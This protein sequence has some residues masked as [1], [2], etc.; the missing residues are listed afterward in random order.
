[1]CVLPCAADDDTLF[2]A[3]PT[4][5]ML[6]NFWEDLRLASKTRVFRVS[7]RVRVRVWVR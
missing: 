3:A 2:G 1:M 4:L 5:N 7:V 6:A